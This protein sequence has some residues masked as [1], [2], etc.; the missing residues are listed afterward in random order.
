MS[1]VSLAFTALSIGCSHGLLPDCRDM[2]CASILKA[3]SCW[4]QNF[5]PIQTDTYREAL[6]RGANVRTKIRAGD[7]NPIIELLF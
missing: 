6:R 7:R 4:E 3:Y 5:A 2:D 1:P